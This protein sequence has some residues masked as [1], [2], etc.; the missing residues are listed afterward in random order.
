MQPSHLLRL[1]APHRRCRCRQCVRAFNCCARVQQ[2]RFGSAP[3]P[4]RTL[5]PPPSA[6][7]PPRTRTASGA[8][9]MHALEAAG[10]VGYVRRCIR[11]ASL[12]WS[13]RRSARHM[14]RLLASPKCVNALFVS[15]YLTMHHGRQKAHPGLVLSLPVAI[16]AAVVCRGC[17]LPYAPRTRARPPSDGSASDDTRHT[18]ARPRHRT[19][20]ESSHRRRRG[21]VSTASTK[22]APAIGPFVGWPHAIVLRRC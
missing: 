10:A 15:P 14:C 19:A 9:C 1:P 5:S 7:P 22:A 2:L 12:S 20:R 17:Y 21:Q 6:A 4:P 8:V 13:G 3:L 16:A 18:A 11:M